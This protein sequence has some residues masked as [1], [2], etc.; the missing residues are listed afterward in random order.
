MEKQCL[1]AQEVHG[2]I[3]IAPIIVLT[4]EQTAQTRGGVTTTIVGKSAIVL[5]PSDALA[6]V[7]E[8]VRLC[9]VFLLF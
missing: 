2:R 9:R 5:A 6:V 4:F 8:A 3:Q 7:P 1:I